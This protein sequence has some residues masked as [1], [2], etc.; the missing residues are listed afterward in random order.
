MAS[1]FYGAAHFGV[2]GGVRPTAGG[3]SRQDTKKASKHSWSRGCPAVGCPWPVA[4]AGSPKINA[5][6]SSASGARGGRSLFALPCG[7]SEVV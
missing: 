2:E 7:A 3:L 6:T 1:S 4:G 5:R